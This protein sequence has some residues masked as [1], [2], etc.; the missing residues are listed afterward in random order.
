MYI[1]RISF[2]LSIILMSQLVRYLKS[3]A[4]L[5][6]SLYS[7]S[8][9]LYTRYFSLVRFILQFGRGRLGIVRHI[10]PK[11]YLYSSRVQ[12]NFY[13]DFPVFFSL[14]LRIFKIQIRAINF[15]RINF[16]NVVKSISCLTTNSNTFPHSHN[17]GQEKNQR[18]WSID[19][20]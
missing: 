11:T 14:H 13:S 9:W 2:L 20:R 4:L 6:A 18:R 16:E 19:G 15:G 10:L 17:Y 7:S 12:I 3:R 1:S 5:N 8:R